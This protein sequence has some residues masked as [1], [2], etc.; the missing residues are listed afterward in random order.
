MKALG[1]TVIGISL[2]A[3]ALSPGGASAFDFSVDP[4]SPAIQPAVSGGIT[5]DDVLVPG[6]AVRFLGTQLGLQ[7]NVTAGQ[8]DNLDALSYG[9]DSLR[10]PL[11]FSV[12]RVSVGLPGTAVY[13]QAALG[14]SDAAGDVFQTQIPPD[15]NNILVVDEQQIGLTGGLSGDDLNGLELN[16]SPNPFVYFSIDRLSAT[17]GYGTGSLAADI[18]ISSLHGSFSTYAAHGIMGLLADDNLDALVLLDGGAKGVADAGDVAWFSLDAFSPT[19]ASLGYSPADI[20]ETRFDGTFARKFTAA[21]LGLAASDELDALDTPAPASL[22]LLLAGL[23]ALRLRR[24][25]GMC[26]HNR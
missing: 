17:N 6:P 7:D 16:S 4:A 10:G 12:D 11:F 21:Q 26:D 19:L 20:F 18:L 1:L 8:Y 14:V 3:L 23:A 2:G 15:N 24:R 22:P 9:Q 5:P 25:R 13:Q